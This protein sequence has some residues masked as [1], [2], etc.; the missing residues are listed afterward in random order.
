MTAAP[1]NLS[2]LI[3]IAKTVKMSESQKAEQRNSFVFGNTRIENESI[4]WEQVEEVGRL[5]DR[6]ERGCGGD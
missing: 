2:R 6:Q 1:M 3:E 4:T 5:L